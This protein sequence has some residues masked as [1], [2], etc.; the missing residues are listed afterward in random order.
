MTCKG[1]S[2]RSQPGFWGGLAEK[3]P[4]PVIAAALALLPCKASLQ[5]LLCFPLK[6]RSRILLLLYCNLFIETFVVSFAASFIGHL[7]LLPQHRLLGFSSLLK[8]AEI[9]TLQH[10]ENNIL[11]FNLLNAFQTYNFTTEYFRLQIHG[12]F[13]RFWILQHMR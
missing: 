12:G 4:Q 2:V 11:H 13:E 3:A 7:L 5:H 10:Y 1:L 6:G 9:I 8:E